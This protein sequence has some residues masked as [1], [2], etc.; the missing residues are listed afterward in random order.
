[1]LIELQRPKTDNKELAIIRSVK[2]ARRVAQKLFIYFPSEKRIF[3]NFQ[4]N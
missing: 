2:I 4:S 1:M 3:V